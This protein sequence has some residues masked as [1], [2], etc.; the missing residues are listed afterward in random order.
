MQCVRA[1]PGSR[2]KVFLKSGESDLA[3]YS[4]KER[5]HL[6]SNL[7]GSQRGF[8]KMWYNNVI[9]RQTAGVSVETSETKYCSP[10]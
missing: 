9:S 2:C 3:S 5:L 10:G 8:S 7:F 6:T 1:K 4:K